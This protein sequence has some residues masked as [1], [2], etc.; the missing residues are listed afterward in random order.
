[1]KKILTIILTTVLLL[2]LS[3]CFSTRSKLFY[4]PIEEDKYT[5]N[6]NLEEFKVILGKTVSYVSI[7]FKDLNKV[8]LI[9]DDFKVNTFGDYSY[10]EIKVFE[11]ELYIGFDY[12]EPIKFDL[13]FLGRANPGRPNA[14]AFGTYINELHK[15]TSEYRLVLDL[16]THIGGH[17]DRV[18]YFILQFNN[19]L[20]RDYVFSVTL[21]N[22]LESKRD[23]ALRSLSVKFESLTR[24]DYEQEEWT[25]IFRINRTAR[26][27]INVSL[28]IEEIETLITNA[29]NDLE[30]VPKKE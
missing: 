17:K 30:N 6:E 11:I 27:A 25:E 3:A 13:E 2:T 5:L 14:Y 26:E 22:E 18:S 21:R 20:D 16:N 23:E 9:D 15:E 29:L 7:S 4:L 8:A 12:E 1:M 10:N 24:E 19:K 28:D